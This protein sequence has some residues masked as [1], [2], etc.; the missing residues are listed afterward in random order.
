MLQVGE[1]LERIDLLAGGFPCQD[2]SFAG[3]GAG[4]EGDRSGLWFEML[5]IVSASYDRTTYS[6]KT[7][8]PSLFEGWGE[9]SLIYPKCGYDA[10]WDSLQAGYFGAP[11][12]RERVFI[13]AYANEEHG[14]AG[15]GNLENWKKP[16][17]SGRDIPCLPLR[18]PRNQFTL[19]MANLAA[20]SLPDIAGPVWSNLPLLE[21]PFI[22]EWIGSRIIAAH[23]SGHAGKS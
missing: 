22:G 1:N 23:D 19:M 4:L 13:L 20:G 18:R 3:L 12:E 7:Y 21:T 9:S 11:H 16:I 2:V 10:E 8:Q 5:R 14:K 17:F 6:W 15:M